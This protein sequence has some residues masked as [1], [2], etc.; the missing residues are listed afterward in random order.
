MKISHLIPKDARKEVVVFDAWEGTL[1][2]IKISRYHWSKG[3]SGNQRDKNSM[4]AWLVCFSLSGAR[5]GSINVSPIKTTKNISS[6]P[7]YWQWTRGEIAA[8][9]RIQTLGH[10]SGSWFFFN[11]WIEPAGN[12]F[13][14]IFL[15]KKCLFLM[16]LI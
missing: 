5:K 1:S 4:Y 12:L 10:P 9:V 3:M 16:S 7:L 13:S 15:S 11:L 2:L 8:L 6:S 14:G